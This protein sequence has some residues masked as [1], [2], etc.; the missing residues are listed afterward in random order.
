MEALQS[1]MGFDRKPTAILSATDEMALGIIHAAQDQGLS[2]PD[3]LDIIGFDNT[4]LSLMVRPQL[5]TV[6][7]PTYDIGAVAMRL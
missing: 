5:S 6:V 7:Q 2:I 3:D 4:R 1:L